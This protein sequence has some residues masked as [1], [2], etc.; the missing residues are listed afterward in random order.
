MLGRLAIAAG[1]H[2]A[3]LVLGAAEFR[4][5]KRLLFEESREY[6][7]VLDNMRGI[8]DGTPAYVAWQHR[9]VGPAC[10]W[11]LELV[12]QNALVA[13]E[14]L[15]ALLLFAANALVFEL[16]QRDGADRR[17]ALVIAA[18]LGFARLLLTYR[19]EYPWDGIDV[20]LFLLFG[21]LVAR[22]NTS[23]WSLPICIVGAVNHETALYV[24]IWYA[25][26]ACDPRR[27]RA[28]RGR[29]LK[30]SLVAATGMLVTIFALRHALYV[31]KPSWG[32]D[33]HDAAPLIGNPLHVAHNLRQ[34][35]IR[36]WLTDKLAVS[37]AFIGTVALLTR[38]LAD[39]RWRCAAIWTL[40][41]L[42]SVVCFGFVNETR[43]YLAPLAFW[44][45][46]CTKSFVPSAPRTVGPA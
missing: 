28:E 45:G 23:R 15:T 42:A 17:R 43:L 12:T 13:L 33:A 35:F 26:C 29:A 34:L 36:N 46:Y 32:T 1:V 25:I 5:L 21:W 4:L 9:L 16:A 39:A 11:V 3:L 31:G 22:Q 7:F 14:V 20:L 37:L 19:L 18:A 24:P 38:A 10:W 2:G 8:L 6:D 30:L 40:L 44:F 27:A 41:V